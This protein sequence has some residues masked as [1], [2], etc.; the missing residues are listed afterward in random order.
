F[1]RLSAK[2][3]LL[4]R[5]WKCCCQVWRRQWQSS[6]DKANANARLRM[7]RILSPLLDCV[8]P[9]AL[10]MS[11]PEAERRQAL[12]S[13]V[14][15]IQAQAMICNS[16]PLQE[17]APDLNRFDEDAW[18]E[19]LSAT[20]SLELLNNLRSI[21]H[22][23]DEDDAD[24]AVGEEAESSSLETPKDWQER[25]PLL[26]DASWEEQLSYADVFSVGTQ[27]RRLLRCN[28]RHGLPFLPTLCGLSPHGRLQRRLDGALQS[29]PPPATEFVRTSRPWREMAPPGR[30]LIFISPDAMK[31]LTCWRPDAVYVLPCVVNRTSGL[32]RTLARQAVRSGAL[33]VRLPLDALPKTV[34]P[35]LE[36]L[37]RVL[38]AMRIS[39]GAQ[40]DWR[41]I[42][43]RLTARRDPN[44]DA[45]L[46]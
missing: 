26:L 35:D 8:C 6:R 7:L 42:L 25:P 22:S 10:D 43:N 46:V 30:A 3:P 45:G 1:Q 33:C 12:I 34:R 11:R 32:N 18:H 27:L 15:A 39:H 13:S 20:D 19:A 41:I 24:A 4:G 5:Q 44:F 28:R 2:A 14:L 40:Q 37:A 21:R 38:L 31:L 16:P 36:V 29:P 23:H 9:A 17:V